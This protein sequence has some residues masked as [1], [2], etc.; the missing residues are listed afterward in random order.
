MVSE[1][2][3]I[4]VAGSSSIA[5]RRSGRTRRQAVYKTDSPPPDH[6][7]KRLEQVAYVSGEELGLGAGGGVQVHVHPVAMALM[8]FHAHL[9]RTEVIGYLGGVVRQVGDGVEV[10]VA[11][12]FPVQGLNE[13][14]LA[15]T[16]RSAYAEVEVDPES[17]VEVVGRVVAKGLL[18]VGWYHSHP[19]AGFTVEPSR[20]DIENQDNYQN[21]MFQE[22]AFVAVI[23][24]PYNEDL[25]DHKP[26]VAFFR[27]WNGETPLRVPY[28]VG[29]GVEGLDE[30][31]RLGGTG[32]PTE[33][34]VAECYNLI[35]GYGAF[36]KRVRLETEWR[37]GILG[38]HKLH[39]ALC[40][41]V[42]DDEKGMRFRE[43]IQ[44]VLQAVEVAWRESGQRDE[45]RKARN[46]EAVKRRKRGRKR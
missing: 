18:V 24:A 16:G 9:T 23:V 2:G 40:D 14:A 26:D 43:C 33:A 7:P 17:S 22:Q 27:V 35:A 6:G 46:R 28:K 32:F 13:R 8:S 20:V 3:D 5:P 45:E 10:V 36:A 1:D 41:L 11:E 4:G 21:Y 42:G 30:Y 37:G 31:W 29:A 38:L 15:K 25:P 34:F 12:A 19:D 39:G 44:G